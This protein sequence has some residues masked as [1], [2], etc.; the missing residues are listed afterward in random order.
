M[1][2]RRVRCGRFGWFRYRKIRCSQNDRMFYTVCEASR[3]HKAAFFIPKAGDRHCVGR[4]PF[5]LICRR[6]KQLKLN[7][8]SEETVNA[9]QNKGWQHPVKRIQGHARGWPERGTSYS[10]VSQSEDRWE[11]IIEN[12]MNMMGTCESR[13]RIFSPYLCAAWTG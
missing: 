11:G 3:A 2:Q 6:T 9:T 8:W 1:Q 4:K 10:I 5:V 12:A 13:N 7:V